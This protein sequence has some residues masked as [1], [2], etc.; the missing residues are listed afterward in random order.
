[1]VRLVNGMYG[2]LNITFSRVFVGT[3]ALTF[4]HV[5]T[6]ASGVFP[7]PLCPYLAREW[8]MNPALLSLSLSL[9]LSFPLSLSLFI[10]VE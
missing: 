9:S 10:D 7:L 6:P 1:M 8:G 3:A 2:H 5:Y 4:F